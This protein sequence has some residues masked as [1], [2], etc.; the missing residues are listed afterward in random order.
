MYLP[1]V[2]LS[3]LLAAAAFPLNAANPCPGMGDASIAAKVGN[4]SVLKTVDP[5]TDKVD[6]TGIYKKN[7]GIQLVKNT[8]YL[9]VPSAPESVMLRFDDQPAEPMHLSSSVEKQLSVV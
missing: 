2:C 9:I 8:L 5:M 1:R 4:W 7:C 3:A 6:C